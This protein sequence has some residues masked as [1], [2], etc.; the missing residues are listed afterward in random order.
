MQAAMCMALLAVFTS[1]INC[2]GGITEKELNKTQAQFRGREVYHPLPE[3]SEAAIS[4]LMSFAYGTNSQL[5]ILKIAPLIAHIA[6]FSQT[7]QAWRPRDRWDAQG[8]GIFT[9]STASMGPRLRVNFSTRIPDYALFY[10]TLRYSNAIDEKEYEKAIDECVKTSVPSQSYHT[11]GYKSIELTT[12]NVQSGACYAYTNERKMVRANIYGTNVLFSLAQMINNSSLSTRGIEVGNVEDGVYYYSDKHGINIRG[13]TWVESRMYIS[14]SLVIYIDL[15]DSTTAVGIFSWVN[16][17]WNDVNVTQ[18]FHIYTVLKDAV[19]T[20][21][22]I[23]WN[24]NVHPDRTAAA[25]EKIHAL[26]KKEIDVFYKKYTDYVKKQYDKM[27][28]SKGFFGKMKV[29]DNEPQLVGLYSKKTLDKM[30]AEYKIALIVQEYIRSLVGDH[31]W[32]KKTD[33]DFLIPVTLTHD[34]VKNN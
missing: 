7:N 22:N 26:P 28:P 33:F 31:T 6:S 27:N 4:H 5:D 1:S 24:N 2:A 16:A 19:D 32:S 29:W 3:K 18:Y 25:I 30:P 15:P 9:H 14:K 10:K 12:P 34:T 11:A 23:A 13:I 17:G 20:L 8:A 21:K